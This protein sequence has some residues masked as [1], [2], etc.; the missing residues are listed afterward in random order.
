VVFCLDRAGLVGKDGPTHH[1]VFDIAYLRCI[2]NLKLAAPMDNLELRN[3]LYTAQLEDAGPVAIRY[4]RGYSHN[5]D[6]ERPFEPVP[7][8]KARTLKTGTRIAVLSLGPL[9]QEVAAAI[10]ETEAPE[11]IGHYDFRF[12]KPLDED[13]LEEICANYQ[14]LVTV[15]DGCL[16]GGFGSAVL[17]YLADHSHSMPVTRLGIADAFVSHGSPEELYR[18][19]GLDR[20]GIRKTL[21]ELLDDA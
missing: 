9:G 13:L 11:A 15:E 1:G 17:E 6:W 18:E 8:G 16:P 21:N 14:H 12:A 20:P 3:M 2:P 5:P 4:P 7:W 10:R 19:Q